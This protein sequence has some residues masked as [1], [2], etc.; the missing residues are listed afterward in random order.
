LSNTVIITGAS[1]G[2]GSATAI[3]FAEKG[4]NVVMNYFRSAES[5]KILA[6][7]L[8]SHGYSV[9]PYYADITNRTSVERM[10]YDTENKF[11]KIDALVNNAGIAQQKLF[12]DI[13]DSDFDKMISV[14][15]KGAFLC[16]QAVLPNM[17]H[18]KSGKIVNIS[19]IWGVSGGACEVHYSA[20]KAALIGL[21]KA[22]AKEVAPS[23]IQ[24]NCIAPG[25]IETRM[26]NNISA[27]DL[28]DFVE[29]IPLGRMGDPA[30]VA[31]LIY[32]LC[33]KGSDYIT[34]QVITQDG[35]L[36]I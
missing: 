8:S 33:G 32:F 3:Y 23:G 1:G 10:I 2:I 15:L 7:S 21:T 29:E 20:S 14:N 22:L 18:Y 36:T 25:L 12:T 6:A 9:M 24:V 11:G 26:N 27:D 17:I 16:S 28:N 13:T 35:G 34:G 4:W 30:E 19:S 5:A 31:E